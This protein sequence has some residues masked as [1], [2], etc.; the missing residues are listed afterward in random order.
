MIFSKNITVYQ[1][2]FFVTLFCIEDFS[3]VQYQTNKT[4]RDWWVNHHNEKLF[5]I[6]TDM[7]SKDNLYLH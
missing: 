2:C 1:K 3:G 6:L 5:N 4:L 7:F